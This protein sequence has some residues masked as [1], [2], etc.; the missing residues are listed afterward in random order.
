MPESIFTAHITEVKN[1]SGCQHF[2]DNCTLKFS[3]SFHIASFSH[4]NKSLKNG[5]I[6]FKFYIL[7]LNHNGHLSKFQIR[8]RAR[9]TSL[10]IH[11]GKF[12]TPHCIGDV[13]KDSFGIVKALMREYKSFHESFFRKRTEVPL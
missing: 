12:N 5:R 1:L 2:D 3:N 10:S 9:Q 4:H 8:E 11:S 13:F 7:F 6:K